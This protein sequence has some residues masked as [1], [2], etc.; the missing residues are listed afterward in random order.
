MIEFSLPSLGADMD[1]GTLLEWKVR[2]GDTVERGQVVAVV[3][4][5]KAAVDVECWQ[6]GEV[7]ELLVEPGVKVPVGTPL[8]T[9]LE[10]GETAASARKRRRPAAPA[11]VAEPPRPMPGP[12]PGT[13]PRVSPAARLRAA[14]LGI[15]V[16]RIPGSGPQGAVTLRD[17]EAARQPAAGDRN[18]AMRQAIASAMSRSKREIPHYYLMECVDLGPLLGWLQAFNAALPPEQRLLPAVALLKAVALALR[19]YPQ[20]NGCWRDGAFQPASGI[21]LGVAIALRQGGLVAPTLHDVADKDLPTLMGEFADLV[22]RARAGSLR[23]S[24]LGDAG[25]TVTLLGD[26]GAESVF[27]VIYPPQVALVGFGRI[28]ERPWVDDGE[29][30][31]RPLVNA[32]LAADHRV[33]DGHYGGR[34]LAEVRRLLQRPGDL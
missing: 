6:A 22:Q 31:V 19:G 27:G 4:T 34:F 18:A 28:A 7:F 1:E 5:A 14:E 25:L 24:E 2:P 9:L 16:E 29:L 11:R 13:R 23:S 17:V 21:H 32:T 15:D 10:A 33:S 8:A 3:D 26:Q 12:P 20:L 30:C